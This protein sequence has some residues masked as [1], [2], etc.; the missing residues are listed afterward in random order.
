MEQEITTMAL[1]PSEHCIA[2]GDVNG[3]IVLWYFMEKTHEHD[4][5]AKPISTT[6]HWHAHKVLALEFTA[7]G[8]YLLSGG[9]EGVLV[10][11]QLQTRHKDF[12]PRLG[13]DI[14]SISV[15]PDQTLMALGHQDN[16]IRIAS[17]VNMTVKQAVMGLKCAQV[18]HETY[19]LSTGL[20]VEPRN[21]H[22]VLNGVPGT[23]QFYNCFTDRHV[24]EV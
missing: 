18:D 3:K 15:S 19:P 4:N 23:L 10:L 1:H 11:W 14:M 13:S 16:T 12:L 5:G 21:D 20:V 6:L 7:D 9:E 24:L 2:T 17:T 22:V 8:S